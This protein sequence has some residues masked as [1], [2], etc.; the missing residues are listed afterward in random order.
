[1]NVNN[2]QPTLSSE[3]TNR[4]TITF[5]LSCLIALCAFG[6]FYWQFLDA[7]YTCESAIRAEIETADED[8]LN[9]LRNKLTKALFD[10]D[11]HEPVGRAITRN[12][13]SRGVVEYFYNFVPVFPWQ[14]GSITDSSTWG[15]WV[16]F[17][18]NTRGILSI[19]LLY[20][21]Y[22]GLY[23]ALS[24]LFEKRAECVT[25][26]G[27]LVA[28]F[29][30]PL[31]FV[32]IGWTVRVTGRILQAI[33]GTTVVDLCFGKILCSIVLLILLIF[34]GVLILPI[35]ALVYWIYTI[36]C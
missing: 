15:Y 5:R 25:W 20:T 22:A 28:I 14:Y 18:A 13:I 34:P 7:Q 23:Y 35:H 21:I 19:L 31:M 33:F 4:P 27:P 32:I 2:N 17:M 24:L 12:L 8:H 3:K 26:E 6:Y 11:P 16:F 29:V 9:Y 1:M 10:F 30:L 36:L